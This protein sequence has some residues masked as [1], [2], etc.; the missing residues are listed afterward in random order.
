[1]NLTS[2]NT[3]PA[4]TP[5]RVL[6]L[7]DR[8]A[9]VAQRKVSAI[10]EVTL[11][12]RIL[13]LNATITAAKAGDAGRPFAAVAHE[14]KNLAVEVARISGEMDEE[15]RSAFHALREVGQSMAA[16]VKGDRL[17]DLALNA[18]EIID[19]NLY[20]RTCDVRWW[21]TDAAVVAAAAQP[22]ADTIS[23]AER[24]L[25][26][27]LSAY[28]VYLDLWICDRSGRIIAHGRPDQYKSV[29]GQSVAGEKWFRDAL[30]TASGNDFS[31]ADVNRCPA[32]GGCAV[33]TYAAAIR[34]G[35][36]VNGEVIGVMGVH[37]NW[38]PQADSVVRGVRLSDTERLTTRALL[39]DAGG[40]VLATSDGQGALTQRLRLETA[41]RDSGHYVDQD[42]RLIA[43][44]RTPGY[45]TYRGL[46]WYGVLEQAAP[47]AR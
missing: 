20:E 23:Y 45:E 5:E 29:R 26:V 13:S 34:A 41:G 12:T 18:I 6:E 19:R 14:V 24:R 21:A 1:M 38:G 10:Q 37:F 15:L 35:G 32:L 28:T 8:A 4:A 36:E 44:H 47:P 16:Q 2:T 3:A 43:F 31:V 30:G 17:V 33:A 27:I 40:R 42:G 39:V 9:E 46:G 22:G 11:Q 7:A 25:A